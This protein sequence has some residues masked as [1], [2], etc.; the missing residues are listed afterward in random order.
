[1]TKGG[2]SRTGKDSF[3]GHFRARSILSYEEALFLKS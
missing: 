1:M 3:L 2:V